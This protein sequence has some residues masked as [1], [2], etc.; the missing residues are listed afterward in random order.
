[1]PL[2]ISW[3]GHVPQGVRVPALVE[4]GDLAPTVLDAAGLPRHPGMQT[5]SL[6]PL[7]TGQAPTDSF[8]DDI[9]CEYL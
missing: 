6:W 3:P 8:R 1:M 9:Y 7:L 5:R 2:I 4:L